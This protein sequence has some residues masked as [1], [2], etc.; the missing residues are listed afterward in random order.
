MRTVDLPKTHGQ[1]R[2]M[3]ALRLGIGALLIGGL[4]GS[5]A[6]WVESYR[7]EQRTLEHAVAG[8][9]HFESR[10]MQVAV[11]GEKIG[12]HPAISTLLTDE[13]VGIR[14]FSPSGENLFDAWGP[15]PE[16][17]KEA[18]R[19]QSHPW[20]LPNN[21]H[22]KRIAIAGEELVQVIL[23]MTSNDGRLAGYVEGVS[24]VFPSA[25]QDRKL[26]IR[27]AVLTASISVFVAALLLYPLMSGL[28]GRTVALSSRL[29]DA[30]LSLLRSL[31]N[32][33]AKRDADTDAHNYRVTCYAVILAEAMGVGQATI[34]E[35]VLG[36]FLHD[37]GKIGIP[38]QILLKPGR[39]TS[40]EIQVMQTHA[41]LGIEI[42]AGNPWLADAEKTIRH[43]HERFDGKGYPDGLA[44][45]AI[46]LTARIFALVD[47]F[48][49]L[50]SVRPYK[51]ALSLEET[52]SIMEREVGQHFD[53]AIHSVFRE[54]APMLYEQGQS[55]DHAQ[56][57]RELKAMLERYFKMKTA[58]EGAAES[59]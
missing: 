52:L 43:H 30:N 18:V 42:V 24:R 44:G 7:V 27:A 2:R 50:T 57:S 3:L 32:A 23:P 10:A 15:L 34:T 49:A 37:V 22:S 40:E 59:A 5:L 19:A 6:Y 28:L 41:V 9:R 4:A 1:L 39:L 20:P 21:N 35:L 56:W 14:V 25:L 53:P 29:L 11:S 38:D 12:E 8:V 47:V 36:A 17:L 58:P 13:F 54:I 55:R 26:Q 16:S 33:V 48:D 51:P 31:G 46:P 45:E